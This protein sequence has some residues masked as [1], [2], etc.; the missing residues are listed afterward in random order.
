MDD[1]KAFYRDDTTIPMLK[2]H[3]QSK[4]KLNNIKNVIWYLEMK[5]SYLKNRSLLLSQKKYIDE[6]LK[7]H[8]MKNC[9]STIISMI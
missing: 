4:Y 1:I 2:E 3:L 7:Y 6:L 8:R 5:I 9:A